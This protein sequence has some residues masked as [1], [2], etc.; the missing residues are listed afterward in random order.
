MVVAVVAVA[1]VA[2][3]V[4]VVVV[5]GQASS[6]GLQLVAPVQAFPALTGCT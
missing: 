6:P 3:T 2:V 4:L 5:A 1:V